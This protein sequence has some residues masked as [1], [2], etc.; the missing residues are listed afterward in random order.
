MNY[1]LT[2]GIGP[3]YKEAIKRLEIQARKTNIFDDI[4]AYT[5]DE[6]EDVDEFWNTHRDFIELNPVTFGYRIWRPYLV[7][8]M[9][10]QMYYGDI[11]LY[12]DAGCE[13]DLQCECP[14]DEFLK[15]KNNIDISSSI[16]ASLGGTELLYSKIELIEF[17]KMKD[18]LQLNTPQI[19]CKS[20]IIQKTDKTL[21]FARDWYIYSCNYSL[22]DNSSFKKNNENFIK[23]NNDQSIFSLLLKKYGLFDTTKISDFD[24]ENVICLNKNDSN[25]HYSAPRVMGSPLFS[26]HFG[27]EFIADYQVVHLSKIVRKNS[28]QFIFET[29]FGSGRTTATVIMSSKSYSIVKYVNCDKNY[30]LYQPLS[31]EIKKRINAKC[32]FVKWIEMRSADLVKDNILDIE[33]PDGIDFAIIDGDPTFEGCLTE[34]IGVYMNMRVE[35]IIYI[36]ADRLKGKNNNVAKATDFF[37]KLFNLNMVTDEVMCSEIAYIVI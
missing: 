35:G 7:F 18:D 25:I 8:R 37:V 17:M 3:K 6:L 4:L 32:S 20:F 15:F 24:I 12:A 21:K 10:E 31:L 13:F 26:L 30:H 9:I 1:F 14:R 28:P 34:L 27:E 5:G 16:I 2:C 11:L 23:H 36:V 29:G 22:I 19:Q 33:F